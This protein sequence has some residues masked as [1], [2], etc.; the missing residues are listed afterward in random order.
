MVQQMKVVS[1]VCLSVA[2]A[3]TMNTVS[4]EAKRGRRRRDRGS[5]NT[6]ARENNVAVH[7][8]DVSIVR[9]EHCPAYGQSCNKCGMKKNISRTCVVDT[10][11]S[12]RLAP[13]DSQLATLKLESGYYHWFQPVTGAQCNVVAL[14]LYKKATK[15]FDLRSVTPTNTAIIPMVV[16]QFLSS[17]KFLRVYGVEISDVCLTAIWLKASEFGL[18]WSL[19]RALE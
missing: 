4:R 9:R 17:G 11:L 18:F 16:L 13:D 19:K 12:P 3:G 2:D 8:A 15:D 7:F 5:R 14:H 1:D 6:G 10:R